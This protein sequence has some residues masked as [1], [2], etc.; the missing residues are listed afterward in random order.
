M[1][2]I[3]L[4]IFLIGL[5]SIALVNICLIISIGWVFIVPLLIDVLVICLIIKAIANRKKGGK[6]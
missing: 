2:T 3:I 6:D 4:I 1:I 5:I